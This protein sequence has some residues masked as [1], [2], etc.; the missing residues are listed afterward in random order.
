M[1]R[2]NQLSSRLFE[3]GDLRVENAKCLFVFHDIR[4]DAL[5][6]CNLVTLPKS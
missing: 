3:N 2:S 6:E 5:R 1:Q 4:K